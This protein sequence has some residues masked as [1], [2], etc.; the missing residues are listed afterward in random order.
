[1]SAY[2]SEQYKEEFP[3][4]DHLEP[5]QDP[6]EIKKLNAVLVEA[7]LAGDLEEAHLAPPEPIEWDRITGFRVPYMRPDDE[8]LPDMDLRAYLDRIPEGREITVEMLRRHKIGAIGV[9][10]EDVL[11]QWSVFNSLVFEVERSPRSILATGQWSRVEPKFVRSV[12]AGVGR[13]QKTKLRLPRAVRGE[14]ERAYNGR[15]AKGRRDLALMDCVMVRIPG[16]RGIEACDLFSDKSHFIHVKHRSA[17]SN[18]SHLWFQGAN[19]AEVFLGDEGFRKDLRARL[20]KHGAKFGDRIP[21]G[22]PN[23]RK[24]EVVFAVIAPKEKP[25]PHGLPFFSQLGLWDTAR[26]LRL[27]SFR[28]SILHIVLY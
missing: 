26:R 27:L 24:F 16:A 1:M 4:V 18:L 12:R 3:W 23:A 6:S 25:V 2:E 10:S 11:Y 7:L 28:V 19:A 9:D 21:E 14:Y 5:I 13:I 8:S 17:S 15:V 22:P 20:T